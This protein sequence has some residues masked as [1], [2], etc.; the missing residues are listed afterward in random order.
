M[1]FGIT[2]PYH[3]PTLKSILILI[4]ISGTVQSWACDIPLKPMT[5]A[6]SENNEPWTRTPKNATDI[7]SHGYAIEHLHFTLQAL[8]Y[9]PTFIHMVPNRILASLIGG[10]VDG[11]VVLTNES[12]NPL[13]PQGTHCSSDYLIIPWGLFRQKNSSSGKR[14]LIAGG[15]RIAYFYNNNPNIQLIHFSSSTL[16]FRT[17]KAG[18]IDAVFSTTETVNFWSKQLDLA[19]H[20]IEPLGQFGIR[21]CFSQLRLKQQASILA[22]AFTPAI[23][24][25]GRH[26]PELFS[27]ES[28]R[29][30]KE[31]STFPLP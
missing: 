2:S 7:S 23:Q 16:M 30:L 6:I 26:Q 5:I 21:L 18:R 24:K 14:P 19:L 8:C 10:H 17:L 31:Y 15:L 25:L 11:A 29:L 4:A 20:P 22:E 9:A 1:K 3:R 27:K 28:Y 12:E 13:L